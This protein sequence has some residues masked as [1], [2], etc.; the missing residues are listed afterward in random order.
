MDEAWSMLELK[1][2]V[3]KESAHLY[4]SNVYVAVH[5]NNMFHRTGLI[6]LVEADS[7]VVKSLKTR[8]L[9]LS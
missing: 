9:L 7:I 5:S 1:M 6:K 2:L 8:F 3:K 4:Y